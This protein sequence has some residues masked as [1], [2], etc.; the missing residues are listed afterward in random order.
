MDH[1]LTKPVSE[2]IPHL[3]RVLSLWDLVLY[4]IVSVTPSATVTV[5]GPASVRSHGF[6]VDAVLIATVAALLTAV[7]YGRMASRYPA[8]GS[9]YT[10]VGHGLGTYWGFLVGWSMLLEYV[11]AP[12]FCVIFG[13]LAAQRIFPGVPYTVWAVVLAALIT[14]LNLIGIRSTART[15]QVLMAVMGAVLLIF[16][17]LAVRYLFHAEGWPGLLSLHPFY[18][19]ETF[20]ISA[21]VKGTAFAGL[22]FVGFDAVTTLAEDVKDPR[23]NILKACVW[24][25][26]FTGIFG[27]LLVYLGQ[28][29]WPN[30]HT[31]TSVETAFLDVAQRAGGV[32]L[33]EAI[34][35]LLVLAQIGVGLTAQ[36]AAARLLFGM[37]RDDI[38]PRRIFARINP[39]RSTPTLNIL[40]VGLIALTGALLTSFELA[41]EL[42]NF[43]AFL[44]YMGVNLAAFRELYLKNPPGQKRQFLRYALVPALGFLFWLGLWCGQSLRAMMFGG[45]WLIMGIVYIVVRT[46]GFRLPPVLINFGQ[47]S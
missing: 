30:Y 11:V 35:L 31:F 14:G 37:G 16:I 12:I 13:S 41:A 34:A 28:R 3:R 43:C 23:R 21:L 19:R 4:G 20:R 26:A 47:S 5:F 45:A 40:M 25:C 38:F 18:R 17:V 42:I 6:C 33:F 8:A 39:G 1:S 24:V 15:N 7:S 2:N 32:R 27:G 10:Y 46:R 44:C 29:V 36:V 22:T 9:A